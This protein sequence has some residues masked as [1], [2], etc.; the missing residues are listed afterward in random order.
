MYDWANS[1]FY[2][3][4][5]T[6]VF[7]PFFIDLAADDGV[8]EERA[9]L[10]LSYGTAVSLGVVAVL[11]PLLGAFAD[12]RALRKPLLA[13]CT[14]LGVLAT[15]GLAT[16]GPVAWLL[17]LVL[18]G[19]ANAGA[20]GA[21][22]FYDA[23]L[24]HL[25]KRE[26]VDRVST[27]G[28]ALGYVG[29]GLL[30]AFDLLLIQK[31]EWF[32]LESKGSA[33]RL[34][35]GLVALWWAGFSLPLL[36]RVPEPPASRNDGR[37]QGS[38]LRVAFQRL[39]N[40][41]REL[42][43]YRQA[44]L[45]LVAFLIYNDGV[46]TIMRM[47][48]AYGKGIGLDSSDMILA[49]MIVQFVG[50]PFA[51]LNGALALRIGAKPTILIGLG[52]YVGIALLG[53]KMSATWHFYALAFLV[54]LVQGGVQALSR[55]LFASMIPTDKAAEFFGFFAVGEKFAGIL[56]PFLFGSVLLAGGESSTAILAVAGFF[57]LGGGMLCFVDVDE[58][59]A[60]VCE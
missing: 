19:I 41:L 52:V 17:G 38:G 1:A 9:L 4:V 23:F 53:W 34:G 33:V 5:I 48:T 13:V 14:A 6:A 25:A 56:G 2:T 8:G 10:Y 32:G 37:R 15:A 39:A 7:P 3:I 16:L 51:F 12:S 18:F 47:A 20:G 40:T 43:R 49:I 44:L 11:A 24:P 29:G 54:A 50:I 55:S 36:L 58:G 31:F 45:L 26:E 59:R 60:A 21:A 57:I 35:F 27:A 22:V 28:F 30:L 42:R 46:L